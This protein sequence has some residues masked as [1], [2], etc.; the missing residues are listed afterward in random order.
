MHDQPADPAA[1]RRAL[2]REK[3][4]T[5]LALPAKVREAAN[6]RILAALRTFLAKRAPTSLGVCAPIRGEPDCL[7]LAAE[8]AAAGWSIVMPAVEIVQAPMVFRHWHP[9]VAMTSDPHGIP[10]PA[11]AAAA[12]PKI[13]LLPLVAFDAAGY[14]LGYGGGYFDRTLAALQPRPLM[15]GVGYEIGRVDSVQPAPHDIPL[16]HI[17][18]ETGLY[19]PR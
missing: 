17:V 11:A 16:D 4:A 13:L 3:I 12:P 19:T 10:V 9:G 8:L 2:R 7:P 14:R 1:V 6:A 5:R 18:T 15:I